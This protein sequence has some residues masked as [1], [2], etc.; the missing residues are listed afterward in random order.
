[1]YNLVS[2]FGLGRLAWYCLLQSVWFSLVCLVP[3]VAIR[4]VW[5]VWIDLLVADLIGLFSL[6]CLAWYCLV[7]SGSTV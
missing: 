7:Q 6:S 5:L 3:P 2:M 1:M 4:S